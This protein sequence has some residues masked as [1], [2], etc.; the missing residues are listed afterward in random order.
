MTPGATRDAWSVTCSTPNCDCTRA[1]TSVKDA[2]AAWNIMAA[3]PIK[4]Y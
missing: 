1:Y 2:V 3:K 4:N